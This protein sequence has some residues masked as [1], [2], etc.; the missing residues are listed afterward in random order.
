MNEFV[1]KKSESYLYY[2]SHFKKKHVKPQL[3][4]SYTLSKINKKKV[5]A[6]SP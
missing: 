3:H 4:A 2:E 1:N 6:K 5:T